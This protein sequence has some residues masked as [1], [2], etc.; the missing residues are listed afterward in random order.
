MKSAKCRAADP[1]SHI[2]ETI[3]C[4]WGLQQMREDKLDLRDTAWL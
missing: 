4:R 3:W 1:S 2:E